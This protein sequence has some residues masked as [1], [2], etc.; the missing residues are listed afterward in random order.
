MNPSKYQRLPHLDS[1][2]CSVCWTH[3]VC[4][5]WQANPSS[6]PPTSIL[7]HSTVFDRTALN[8]RDSENTGRPRRYW[9]VIKSEKGTP[10]VGPDF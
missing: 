5:E 8:F 9:S 2:E 6:R 1:C 4:N 7:N 3:R 10:F